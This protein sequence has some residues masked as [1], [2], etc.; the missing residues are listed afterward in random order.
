MLFFLNSPGELTI[1]H[2]VIYTVISDIAD[3]VQAG[4]SEP[5][6]D[7]VENLFGSAS[8]N[9]LVG[10]SSSASPSRFRPAP[11]QESAFQ[12]PKPLPPSLLE[13]SDDSFI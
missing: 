13:G 10:S 5:D 7:D 11:G 2:S 6:A 4:A 12:L 1:A 9:N 8:R 3:R